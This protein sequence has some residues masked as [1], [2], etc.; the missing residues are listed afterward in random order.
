MTRVAR[1][2]SI[3][4]FGADTPR[5]VQAAFQAVAQAIDQ[6]TQSVNAVAFASGDSPLPNGLPAGQ[7]AGVFL[8]GQITA[9]G[10]PQAFNH[11]LRR[12]P[13]GCFEVL[14]IPTPANAGGG[15]VNLAAA[16]AV[17]AMDSQTITITCPTTAKVF[18]LIV[19]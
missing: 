13:V 2:F 1:K 8:V 10:T 6:L 3:G 9:G 4:P 19:F 7:F 16:L 17:T 12:K 11:T 5:E 14:T 15:S 18:T